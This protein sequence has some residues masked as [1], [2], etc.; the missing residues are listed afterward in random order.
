VFV[1]IS[2]PSVSTVVQALTSF[3]M[4]FTQTR[5]ERHAPDGA[6]RAS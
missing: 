1:S 5:Q 3:G 6:R 2:M 4:P